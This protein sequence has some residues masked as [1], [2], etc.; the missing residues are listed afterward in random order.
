MNVKKAGGID[1]EIRRDAWG[2]PHL[3]AD[4]ET[5]LSYAQGYNAAIDR[6]WQ[7]EVERHRALG[8]TASFLGV[9]AVGWDRF[10]R[11]AQLNDTARRCFRK[12]DAGTRTWIRA[13]VSGVNAGLSETRAPEF[14][15][16][17]LRPGRWSPWTPLGIWLSTHILFVGFPTKLWREE[18]ARR[19]GEDHVE[20]FATEGPDGSGSNGWLIPGHRSDSG[21]PILAGDPHRFIEAPGVYQQIHL[22]CP[23]YD[24]VGLAVPGVPGIAHFGHT[25]SVAWAI[26]NAMADC[27]DLYE[28][29]LRR[30]EGRVEAL[31]PDGFR[32]AQVYRDT[33]EVLGAAPVDIEVIETERGPVVIGGPDDAI[34]ISLRDPAR[35]REDLGFDALPELLRARSVGD[36]DR[37]LDSW[38]EPV[39]VVQAADAQGGLLYRV[40]GAVPMRHRDNCLRVVPAWEPRHAWRGFHE[41]LPHRAV[42]GVAVMANQRDLAAPFGVEFAPRYR[43]RRIS[44]LLAKQERWSPRD[45]A[46]IHVD[47]YLP[48]AQL[49]LDRLS[50]LEHL[51]SPATEL[52]DRLLRWNR[53]MDGD[54]HD[55][56]LYA[57]VRAAL[58]RRVAAHPTLAAL[59][60]VV[61]EPNSYPEL[62]HPWLVL[63]PRVAFALERLL[64]TN[65][66]PDL[67][68][69]ALV[70]GALEDVAR[71]GTPGAT[72]AELH[73]L[74]P[75]QALP[76]TIAEGWPGLAGDHD[77]VLSTYSIPGLT[78]ECLRAP[79][80]RYI[81]DLAQRD[82]SSWVVPLG[83]SG[84]RDSPHQHDQLPLWL[85]GELVPVV[86]DFE[87]LTVE[88]TLESPDPGKA[89]HERV[90]PGFGTVRIIP[91]RP[92]EDL[93]LIYSWVTEER[94]RFWGMGSHSREY[95]LEI[96]DYLDSLTTH[97]AYLV[98]RDAAPAALFQTYEPAAD[99]V[100][101]C[102][103][104]ES[105][106]L[107]V[108]L[109]M[110][111]PVR[112]ETGFTP[113]ILSVLLDYA[114]SNPSVGRIVVEPDARNEKAIARFARSGFALGP[115]IELP[116]KRARL[117]FLLREDRRDYIEEKGNPDAA[118]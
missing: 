33:I 48:S 52:R 25:G 29:R 26:T 103:P 93:D 46:A 96:Y 100:G 104:V 115:E 34:A 47:T 9:G 45:M 85:R 98:Y 21:A 2:I 111:P 39:N 106:D 38:V 12:L 44:Q 72:W 19:L 71:A 3:R 73:R 92:E 10:A 40:A 36:V 59:S 35:V 108:H 114:F 76:H 60:N 74:T 24:V 16:C 95:V 6:G 57:E 23:D 54:S 32:P 90:V 62:F 117:M 89:V 91:V 87:Q 86:T 94:A 1:I 8:T 102:Y 66:L 11:Q 20:L 13:Y 109:M 31:G 83:A 49:I 4:T 30:R 41:A 118:A 81:W 101:D 97:H 82:N 113:A 42:E 58:V 70:R 51:G 15:E 105:G 110:A 55:A 116:E 7:I 28:E 65:A 18:V 68:N 88:A 99:P 37:A 84:L 56:A 43:E 27:Q 14:A 5:A 64:S 53:H 63:I 17:K 79:A 22:A 77:C 78:H 75:W 67:D 112:P 69:T 50:Q 61:T 80:A 107:G